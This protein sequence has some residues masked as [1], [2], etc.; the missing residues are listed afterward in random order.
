MSTATPAGDGGVIDEALSTAQRPSVRP[1]PQRSRDDRL[2]P[3]RHQA[4]ATR[5]D[6]GAAKHVENEQRLGS[7]AVGGVGFGSV[8]VKE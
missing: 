4:Q 7:L 3:L 2:G 8:V 5:P 1:L 6:R